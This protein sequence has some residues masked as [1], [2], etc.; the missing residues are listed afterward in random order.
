MYQIKSFSISH[1][2]VGASYQFHDTTV[3]LIIQST[4]EALHLEELFPQY[5]TEVDKYMLAINKSKRLANTKEITEADNARDYYLRMFFKIVKTLQK[6][7]VDNNT[8]DLLWSVISPYE[9]IWNNEINKQT[10]QAKGLLRDI[11]DSIKED[12]L[13]EVGLLKYFFNIENFNKEVEYQMELR[14][15]DEAVKESVNTKQQAKAVELIYAQI[16]KVVNAFAIASPSEAVE[17]FIQLQNANV[18]E[19]KRVI[20]GMRPG[21]SGNEKGGKKKEGEEETFSKE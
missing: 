3:R 19:Y 4:P 21:G 7:P 20:S 16:V 1:L 13:E 15:K 8:G 5:K 9:G 14:I 11:K 18:D 17:K 2:L 6:D 10:S 12:I